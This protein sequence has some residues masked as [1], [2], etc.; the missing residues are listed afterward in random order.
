MQ[1]VPQRN[2]HET[3]PKFCVEFFG[4]TK[5][6]RYVFGVNEFSEMIAGQVNIDGFIDEYT[7]ATSH[8]GKPVVRLSEVPRESL[9]VSCVTQ[10]RPLSA[11]RKLDEAGIIDYG[12]YFSMADLSE[13]RLSQVKAVTDTRNDYRAHAAQYQWVR[14]RLCDETSREVFDRILNFR[15]TGNLAHMFPFSY[16]ADRQYFEPF[17]PLSNGEVFVDGGA[18]DGF[19]SREF[20][21]RCPNYS[22]IHVFEPSADTLAVARNKLSDLKRV[23]YHPLGLFDR[24]CQ[25]RFDSTAGSACRIV[26][27]GDRTIEVGRLD[28]VVDERVSFIKLDLEGAELPALRGSEEH[29]RNDHPK[30]AVA[31]YHQGADLWEIPAYVL[32]LR[33]DYRLYLRHYTEGWTETVMFFVPNSDAA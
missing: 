17:A 32:S 33:P 29:I 2:T 5:R 25:L 24:S 12:D 23:H 6:K 1:C 14:D 7:D 13:G 20:A 27:D 16:A 19:T 15:L 4:D 26:E 9:V 30:L 8:M 10:A 22:S 21:N 31:V 18:Y 11:L 28:D 3:A